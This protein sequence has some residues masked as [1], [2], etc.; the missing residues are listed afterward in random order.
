MDW[1]LFGT[2]F[3]SETKARFQ[4]ENLGMRLVHSWMCGVVLCDISVPIAGVHA[5][6][7]VRQVSI[8]PHQSRTAASWQC[9][10]Q[11]RAGETGQVCFCTSTAVKLVHLHSPPKWRFNVLFQGQLPALWGDVSKQGYCIGLPQW[12]KPKPLTGNQQYSEAPLWPA[13]VIVLFPL[14]AFVKEDEFS[15]GS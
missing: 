4:H 9:W 13:F 2:F 3:R 11:A 8:V 12:P 10:D 14:F 1:S 6:E 15:I 5:A 7:W